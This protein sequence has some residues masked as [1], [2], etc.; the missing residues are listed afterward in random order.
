MDSRRFLGPIPR[1]LAGEANGERRADR[2][3]G[4]ADSALAAGTALDPSVHYL[5]EV[6]SGPSVSTV[7]GPCRPARR[8]AIVDR[9]GW[10]RGGGAGGEKGACTSRFWDIPSQDW[11]TWRHRASLR[12]SSERV[13]RLNKNGGTKESTGE[14][15]VP[16]T[17]FPRRRFR[18]SPTT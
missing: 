9:S 7:R 15:L 16:I 14:E 1:S 3:Q 11:A 13:T 12:P 4:A 18:S 17:K 10:T 8:G 6:A 2:A 5:T